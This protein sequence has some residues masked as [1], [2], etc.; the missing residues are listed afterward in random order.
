[1]RF[2]K[3]LIQIISWKITDRWDWYEIIIDAQ[4]TDS[5]KSLKDNFKINHISGNVFTFSI[6]EKQN[7]FRLKLFGKKIIFFDRNKQLR[8]MILWRQVRIDS[9]TVWLIVIAFF[10]TPLTEVIKSRSIGIKSNG[11]GSQ[12]EVE[13][14]FHLE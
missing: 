5:Y 8:F 3:D 9:G 11:Y 6:Y 10:M 1:M 13:F 4:L 2:T 14:N 7:C 12:F